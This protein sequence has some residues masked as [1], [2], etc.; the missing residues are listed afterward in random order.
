MEL[1]SVE[2]A[3]LC[4]TNRWCWGVWDRCALSTSCT[5]SEWRHSVQVRWGGTENRLSPK[6]KVKNYPLQNVTGPKVTQN[7]KSGASG[8]LGCDPEFNRHPP[9][10]TSPPVRN[11]EAPSCFSETGHAVGK[12]LLFLSRLQ[13]G[14]PIWEAGLRARDNMKCNGELRRRRSRW[15]RANVLACQ[16]SESKD[17]WI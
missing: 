17:G 16:L 2:A 15:Q 6:E 14:N 9:P 7:G 5:S 13:R 11:Q 12:H 1:I 8:C 10:P 4:I 3:V